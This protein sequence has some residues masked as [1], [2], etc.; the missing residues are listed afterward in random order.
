MS[1]EH[2][3]TNWLRLLANGER[4]A[5]QPLWERY[6]GRLVGLASAKL[7]DFP[8]RLVDEED[9]ALSAFDSFCRGVEQGRFPQLGDRTN[10]WSLLVTITARKVLN[11]KRDQGRQKRGGLH[12]F[13]E[14]PHELEE[15]LGA[16][17]TPDFALEMAEEVE[18]LLAA[19]QDDS[20]RT[21]ALWKMEGWTN[22]EIA[23]KVPCSPRTVERR[24]ELI[25]STWERKAAS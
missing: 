7:R 3:V 13:T 14:S 16:E 25:R 21:L 1:S 8:R 10:L 23:E 18:R 6:F 2:S 22:A 4:D 17:P 19:L 11:L 15:V 9:I 20:L 12:D 5:A 24:L